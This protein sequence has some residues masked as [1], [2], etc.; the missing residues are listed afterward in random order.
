M[1][2]PFYAIQPKLRETFT[3]RARIGSLKIYTNE[4]AIMK[5]WGQK[6]F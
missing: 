3:Y 4:R 2:I 5:K 1:L 6:S